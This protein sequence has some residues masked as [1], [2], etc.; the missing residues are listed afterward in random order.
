ML[1]RRQ[2]AT[3]AALGSACVGVPVLLAQPKPEKTKVTIAA[4]GGE[5]ALY[6]LPLTVAAQLGYFQ[7]E[8]L[9]VELVDV[10][11]GSAAW[12]AAVKGAVDVVSGAYEHTIALQ[13]RGHFFQAF[14]LQGRAPQIAIGVSTRNLPDY[15]GLADLRG[16]W[17]GISAPGSS[18]NLTASLVLSR[19][20]LQPGDVRFIGVGTASSA[21]AA[22]RSGQLDA[23]S[24]IDPVMTM[25]E[26]RGEL[27]IVCDT[28]TL[29]GAQE[30]FGG[31][32]PAGCL[33]APQTFVQQ[34]PATCQALANAIVHSL[35]WLQTAGPADLVKAVPEAHLLGDRALYLASFDKMREAIALDGL[36][37]QV[38]ARTALRALA[39]MDPLVRPDTL[40]LA[41]TYTNSFAQRAKDRFR[42]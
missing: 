6:H 35:K 21:L 8:G 17:M 7:A 11:G 24:N 9:A 33:Y 28:R 1:N 18:T 4:V 38:G 19:A 37:P 29:K 41:R 15:R 30:V 16:K 34:H 20:G 2:F 40:D 25:L 5:A 31:P 10:P 39:S 12:P 32:M 42:V 3:A 23:I 14:V 26:Q 36:L 22:V 27:R 13:G